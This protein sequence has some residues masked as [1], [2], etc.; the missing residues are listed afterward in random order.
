MAL[1]QFKEYAI[2]RPS[3]QDH[4]HAMIVLFTSPLQ[5]TIHMQDRSLKALI[6][7]EQWM[8]FYAPLLQ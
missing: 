8:V 4:L 1:M 5:A 6:M 3:H 7:H 2:I